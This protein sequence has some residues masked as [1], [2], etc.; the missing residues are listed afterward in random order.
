MQTN[1]ISLIT[2]MTTSDGIHSATA[3]ADIRIREYIY[4][5]RI[6]KMVIVDLGGISA[7]NGAGNI[8]ITQDLPI[9][10]S[11]PT[12]VLR[13]D[14]AQDTALVYGSMGTSQLR[15]AQGYNLNTNYYGQ[16]IYLTTD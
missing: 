4:W 14:A 8:L 16:L 10:R 12:A 6:G 1:P 3:G 2:E 9:M 11:R 7:T 15:F 5:W 13:S